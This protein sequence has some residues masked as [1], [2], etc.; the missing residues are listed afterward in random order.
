MLVND[1]FI[2]VYQVAHC[3]DSPPEEV[4][5]VIVEWIL[6]Y[7]AVKTSLNPFQTKLGE[8]EDLWRFVE[9]DLPEVENDFVLLV[10]DVALSVD[11][12]A[13]CVNQ[14]AVL[15]NCFSVVELYNDLFGSL[16]FCKSADYVFDVKRLSLVREE[17]RNAASGSQL[18]MNEP[19][20]AFVVD[21]VFLLIYQEAALVHRPEVFVGEI[22][23]L[24]LQVDWLALCVVVETA[25]DLMRIEIEF[26]KAVGHGEFSKVFN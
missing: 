26:F 12:V 11:Q 23:V 5:L 7:V 15:V 20:V 24:V 17:E 25:H 22:A 3:V 2:V 6:G 14:P 21:D 9:E 13:G 18:S 19:N 16:V 8:V 4:L 1:C 10:N